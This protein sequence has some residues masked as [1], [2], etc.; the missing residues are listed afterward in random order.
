MIKALL[1][2]DGYLRAQVNL[3]LCPQMADSG[4]VV[5]LPDGEGPPE[6][7][8][9]RFSDEGW[10]HAPTAIG[11]VFVDESTPPR[12]M[13]PTRHTDAPPAGWTAVRADAMA[14]IMEAATDPVHSVG[15]MS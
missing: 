4:R 11:S 8:W 6:G 3:E 9:W 12:F 7:Q 13:L 1:D 5:E 15:G 14:D 10:A 2:S